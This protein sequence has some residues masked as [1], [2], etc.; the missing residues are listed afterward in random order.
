MDDFNAFEI[1][2]YQIATAIMSKNVD[3][4]SDIVGKELVYGGKLRVRFLS[5][6]KMEL[7]T[8]DQVSSVDDSCLRENVTLE[9][10]HYLGRVSVKSEVS[11]S[12]AHLFNPINQESAPYGKVLKTKLY[13]GDFVS[14]VQI[15]GDLFETKLVIYTHEIDAGIEIQTHLKPIP[16]DSRNGKE[17]ILSVTTEGINNT[18]I[19]ASPDSNESL[20]THSLETDAN[21]LFTVERIYGYK[22]G[23]ELH[24]SDPE[25]ADA[26][27][28][29][30]YYPVTSA[31]SIEDS[32]SLERITLM[33]DRAQGGTSSKVG[34]L[35]L[36]IHRVST[37]DDGCGSDEPLKDIDPVTG[38]VREI[39]L[40]HYLILSKGTFCFHSVLN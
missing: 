25:L 17:I 22:D 12:G 37:T 33:N 23:Y 39:D 30:N 19:V 11:G 29:Y 40:V 1:K 21:G 27:V 34:S 16:I 5:E 15:I 35:E 3:P 31:I 8:C 2:V 36:M 38:E 10:R 6:R 24:Y 4:I 13:K 20:K 14:I 7:R 28:Q 9:Y 26:T 18:K 32:E